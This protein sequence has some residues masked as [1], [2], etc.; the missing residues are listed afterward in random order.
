ML[1]FICLL[2][3]PYDTLLPI[4]AKE[5]FKGN[6]ETFGYINSFI[7]LGAVGGAFYLASLKKGADLKFVLLVN[8]LV[9]GISLVLFSHMGYFPVAMV[10]AVA[11]GFGTMSQT[12]ICNT[13]IQYNSDKKMRGRVMS[14]LLLAVGMKP[15]GSLLIGEVSQRTNAQDALLFQGIIAIVIALVFS[16]YLRSNKLDKS[17]MKQ[18]AQGDDP[19]NEKI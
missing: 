7:G 13:I 8:T 14:I 11:T 2:V 17:E 4:F 18:L 3:L 19:A 10:C 6:A 12:T 9:L 15:L 5:I 16:K 1:S